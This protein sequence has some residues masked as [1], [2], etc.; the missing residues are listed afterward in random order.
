MQ[1]AFRSNLAIVGLALAVAAYGERGPVIAALPVAVLTTL[2]NVLAVW[3]LNS[4]LGTGASIAALVGG[5]VRNPLIIGIAAGVIVALSGLEPSAA[6][7]E[8][9]S[10]DDSRPYGPVSAAKEEADSVSG[11]LAYRNVLPIP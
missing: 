1:A 4:T 3:V 2:Y 11:S 8:N 5:I 9:G 10:T 7:A 6:P